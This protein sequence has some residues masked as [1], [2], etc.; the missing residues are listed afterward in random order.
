M[1][2]NE[3]SQRSPQLLFKIEEIMGDLVVESKQI[4]GT[5]PTTILKGGAGSLASLNNID[6]K[7]D[8]FAY[9]LV[10]EH[11]YRFTEK[12]HLPTDKV[13]LT[14]NAIISTREFND[15]VDECLE[16]LRAS[17]CQSY[18]S[19]KAQW[20]RSGETTSRKLHAQSYWEIGFAVISLAFTLAPFAITQANFHNMPFATQGLTNPEQIRAAVNRH[21]DSIRSIGTSVIPQVSQAWSK[22]YQAQLNTLQQVNTEARNM[23][24]LA[25]Q[26]AQQAERRKEDNHHATVQ[27]MREAKQA[28]SNH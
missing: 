11:G 20:E 12:A 21:Q 19:A 10:S 25:K 24:D 22:S 28:T 18:E 26:A 23:Y 15:I 13:H 3:R 6:K 9:P 5:G 7:V 16:I 1:T 4:Q 27:S 8:A 2:N 14:R 17:H